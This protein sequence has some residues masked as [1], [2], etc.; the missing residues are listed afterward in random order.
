MPSR[1]WN[2]SQSWTLRLHCQKE[3]NQ[4]NPSCCPKATC[5]I[6]TKGF[7][8]ATPCATTRQ[9]PI[10]PRVLMGQYW[11][12]PQDN[13]PSSIEGFSGA[14]PRMPHCQRQPSVVPMAKL[15]LHLFASAAPGPYCPNG[16]WW[17]KESNPN[18]PHR[19]GAPIKLI[20][21]RGLPSLV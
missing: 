15:R 14:A 9:P 21:T 4:D 19:L 2:F 7:K 3:L 5:L 1:S 20:W 16:T 10:V 6:P 8:T 17:I 12:L 11:V 18:L 13:T